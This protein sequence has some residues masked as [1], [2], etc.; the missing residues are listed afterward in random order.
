MDLSDSEGGVE[1]IGQVLGMLC[2]QIAE[3]FLERQSA[4][5]CQK[6]CI[7]QLRGANYDHGRPPF[8]GF[9]CG[10][11]GLSAVYGRP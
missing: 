2:E 11:P 9:I 6:R 4:E 8:S 3:S 5:Q 1:I 10:P 7:L